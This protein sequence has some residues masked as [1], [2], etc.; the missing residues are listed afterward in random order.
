[1]IGFDFA[2]V[3]QPPPPGRLLGVFPERPG[4]RHLS[5]LFDRCAWDVTTRLFRAPVSFAAPVTL[6]VRDLGVG[7]ASWFAM[8]NC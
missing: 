1:V 8:S 2:G 5:L 7:M 6:L 4:L 3:L